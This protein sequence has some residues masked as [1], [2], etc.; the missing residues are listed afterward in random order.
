MAISR[1]A[2]IPELE[3]EESPTPRRIHIHTGGWRSHVLLVDVAP[4]AP[5]RSPGI[6]CE[7]GEKAIRTLPL[8]EHRHHDVD[9][10]VAADLAQHAGAGRRRRF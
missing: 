7:F 3:V 6:E 5:G 10:G 4:A 2:L 9:I 1:G 8:Y